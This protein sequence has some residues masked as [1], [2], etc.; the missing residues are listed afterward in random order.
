MRIGAA[1]C[2]GEV[3]GDDAHFL[4]GWLSLASKRAGAMLMTAKATPLVHDVSWY[5]GR[6][7][8]PSK[9]SMMIIWP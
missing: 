2:L 5:G 3:A 1:P 8:T 4:R 9:I 7:V 6:P